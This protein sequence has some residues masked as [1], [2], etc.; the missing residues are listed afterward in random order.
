MA[1]TRVP[2]GIRVEFEEQEAG[3]LRQLLD[4]MKTLLDADIEADPV[5]KRLFP[6]AYES[7]ED[8]RAYRELVGDELRTSKLAALDEV[9]T[10]LGDRGEVETAISEESGGTW[11]AVMNDIRLA[12]GTRNDVTEE[13]MAM[14]PD[15]DDLDASAMFVLHWLGWLQETLLESITSE[16]RRWKS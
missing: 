5:N 15:S 16:G 4:E 3:L 12:I 8:S 7:A 10:A 11:L 14:E 13:R 9:R 2:D 1:F 6:D